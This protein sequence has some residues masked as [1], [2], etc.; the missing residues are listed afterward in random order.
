MRY[1]YLLISSLL[2]GNCLFT[3]AQT[4]PLPAKYDLAEAYEKK[5][6][7]LTQQ[8]NLL[9][10]QTRQLA[11][12]NQRQQAQ[13][14]GL[15][16]TLTLRNDSLAR[17]QAQ[18]ST[19]TVQVSELTAGNQNLQASLTQR[20]TQLQ[21]A[22]TQVAQL[23]YDKQN[24]VDKRIL[25]IYHFPADDVR[26]QFIQSLSMPESGFQYDDGLVNDEIKITRNF[27]DQTEAWWVFDKTLDTVL[28]LV[29]RI[30]PHLYDAQKAIV[31]GE[32]RVLQKT[33]FSNKPFE[34]QRDR[35]KTALYSEKTLRMLEGKLAGTSDK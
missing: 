25:R 24:L 3:N 7:S 2:F 22:T 9:K 29:I 23:E 27:N 19:L 28:E 15:Q 13:L 11:A 34:E 4:S 18:I 6:R 33:R 17:Q 31:F 16:K 35:E 10:V 8:T 26:K 30:K 20:T 32:A 12:D 21:A 14:T 1:N 5:I